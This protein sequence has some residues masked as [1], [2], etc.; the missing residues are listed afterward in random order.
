MKIRDWFKPGFVQRSAGVAIAPPPPPPTVQHG[1]AGRGPPPIPWWLGY[2]HLASAYLLIGSF[3][4]TFWSAVHAKDLQHVA[5]YEG[6]L[7][8]ALGVPGGM[9]AFWA[10]GALCCELDLLEDRIW[11]RHYGSR[12]RPLVTVEDVRRRLERFPP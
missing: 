9:L 5:G 10:F 12:I 3:V 2:A 7:W 1:G 11:E 6:L 4:F 8:L